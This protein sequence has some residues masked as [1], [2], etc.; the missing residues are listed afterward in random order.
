MSSISK[1]EVRKGLT[2]SIAAIIITFL[3]SL[4]GLNYPF[5]TST[6]IYILMFSLTFMTVGVV[7]LIIYFVNPEIS[8]GMWISKKKSKN[9]DN[10][11]VLVGRR[12]LLV[13]M[14]IGLCVSLFVFI[15][16]INTILS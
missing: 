11:N 14:T 2:Y 12:I 7:S 16:I 1:E 15:I 4:L 5:P 6:G 13:I 8:Y 9:I 3:F 10:R